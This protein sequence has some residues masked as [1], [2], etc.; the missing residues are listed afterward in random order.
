MVLSKGTPKGRLA[1]KVKAASSKPTEQS[2]SDISPDNSDDG[3]HKSAATSEAE[4]DYEELARTRNRELK[5]K[6]SRKVK[7]VDTEEFAQV[8]SSILDQDTNTTGA[9]I[10]AKNRTREREIREEK[11]NYRARKALTEEKRAALSKDRVIPTM[12][13]FDY[14]RKLRKTAT[15]GVIKLFNVVKAQQTELSE[16]GMSKDLQAEKMANMSKTKFLSLLK[17]KTS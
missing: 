12:Q 9:P 1:V 13:N 11:L 4:S 14:E 6:R 17:A 3:G 16:I 15:K 5:A 2:D 8:L 10:M 7:V